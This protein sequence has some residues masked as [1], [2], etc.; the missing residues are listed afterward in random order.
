MIGREPVA[1]YNRPPLTK[2]LWKGETVD[3]IWRKVPD[4]NVDL[5]L[6]RTA[7]ELDVQGKGVVDDQGAEYTFD[8]LLLA[9]GGTP[10][11][12]PF[13][14]DGVIYYRTLADYQRL[15]EASGSGTR[16]GVIGGGFIG[17]ELAAGLN[18]A[19]SEVVMIL[20]QAGIGGKMFPADLA[21]FVT[22]YYRERGVTVM[23][24]S[25]LTGIEPAGRQFTMQITGGD[26][27]GMEQVDVDHI[28]AGL[29]IRPNVELAE[30]AGLEV[31]D[32]IV[33]DELLRTS[34]PD[35]YAAGDAANF[36]Q[37]AL[38]KRLRVEHEDNANRM[39]RQAGRIMA[40][41]DAPYTHLPMFYS[42]LFDLGYEA[43]GEL[44]SRLE[45]V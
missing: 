34:A 17:S 22:D 14:G 41:S 43:V 44:D 27:G 26:G 38:D 45:M 29:G 33:V 2:G 7:T 25:R 35:I 39:G 3:S 32:G 42:D 13:G 23:T 4:Q 36:A 16:I 18:L 20:P 37:P 28:V 9:T 8:K 5:H 21:A 31:D 15:R 30:R 11:H 40:G 12:L 10:N 6:G 1:P 24:D 19:G